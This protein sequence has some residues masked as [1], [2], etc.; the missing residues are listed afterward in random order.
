M[1]ADIAASNSNY[2]THNMK[3]CLTALFLTLL[4]IP[5]MSEDSKPDLSHMLLHSTVRI[6]AIKAN[7]QAAVGTGF[8]YNIRD[9]SGQNTN[10]FIPLIVTCKHVIA[11]SIIVQLD[12]ALGNSNSFTRSENHFPVTVPSN[13]WI[14]DPNT[15]VDLIVLP[16]ASLLEN[17]EKQGK[18]LDCAPLDNKLVPSAN[19]LKGLE[20]FQEIYLIG[21]PIGISDEA[22]NLPI[23]RRGITATDPSVDYDGRKE[24]MIDAAVFPG[25][26]GSPV[27][28]AEEGIISSGGMLGFGGSRVRL[29]GILYGGPEFSADGKVEVK[30]IPT[31]FDISS[32]TKIP[33]NL[34]LVIKANRLDDFQSV[35]AEILKKQAQLKL[36]PQK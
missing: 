15:N 1:I 35:F 27:L 8:F 24:F 33:M 5:L 17:L 11:D 32:E 34:G 16:I 30:N 25:S 6:V 12:C 29:L 9:V 14:G 19:D 7:G 28:T 21:Y 22:N 20:A 3:I 18:I 36:A 31:A 13:M 2:C 23:M 10:G 4:T 26:S